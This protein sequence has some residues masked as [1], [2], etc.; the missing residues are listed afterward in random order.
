[1][2]TLSALV[3]ELFASLVRLVVVFVTRVALHDPLAFVSFLVG[4]VVTTATV[5]FVGYLALRGALAAVSFG[6]PPGR[7]PPQRD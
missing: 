4:A 6:G 3:A 5:G 2:P 7:A 1:M